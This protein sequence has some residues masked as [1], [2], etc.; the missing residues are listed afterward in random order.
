V[1]SETGWQTYDPTHFEAL[2]AAED[3]HFWFRSRSAV[4]SAALRRLR[5]PQGTPRRILEIGCGTGHLLPVLR[6]SCPG[7]HV[8]GMDLYAEGLAF[9][10]RRSGSL[11]RAD[12]FAAPFGPCFD[13]IGLFD[14]IE[15]LPDDVA[16]LRVLHEALAPGGVVMVTVPAHAWLWSRFDEAACHCRRYECS[17]L[18][19]A[20][21]DGG[22]AV[23][24]MTEFMSTTLPLVWLNRR[25]MRATGRN[26]QRRRAPDA[27]PVR[28]ELKIRPGINGVLTWFLMREAQWI[29]RGGHLPWGT[30]ILAV[31]RKRMP[32]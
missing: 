24:D 18:E 22:Y 3:R 12:A 31:A 6:H 28:D 10:R 27:D 13:V 20:L 14:V 32:Q 11:V 26:R 23:E 29:G 19:R 30:S 7:A 8:V 1:T 25:A 17:T 16:T 21:V 2:A 5:A 9:A 4:I 15:H